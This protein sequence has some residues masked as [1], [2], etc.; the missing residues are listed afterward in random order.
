MDLA[1]MIL[2]ANG[3]FVL[4]LIA[5][6]IAGYKNGLVL[7]LINCIGWIVAFAA[8]ALFS[9]AASKILTLYP[10]SL[11]P[12]NDT[13][14]GPVFQQMINQLVWF[15]LISAFVKLICLILKPLA[16]GFQKIPVLGFFNNLAGAAFGIVNMWIWTSIICM[17]LQLP[18]IAWGRDVIDGSLL[19]SASLVSDLIAEQIDISTEEINELMSMIDNIQNLDEET[20]QKIQKEL[21]EYGI[22]QSQIDQI[23][24]SL[25]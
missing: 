14:F 21:A 2:I 13:A 22:T 7:S 23:F 20:I 1:T 10:L 4:G 19:K 11:T 5:L 25:E 3:L 8:A 24:E 9:P 18:A 12:M 17:I 16:K 15:V 6:M